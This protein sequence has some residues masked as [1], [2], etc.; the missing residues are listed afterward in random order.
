VKSF[1]KFIGQE[2]WHRL[3]DSASLCILQVIVVSLVAFNESNRQNDI[4]QLIQTNCW[5]P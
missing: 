3:G 5:E 4:W 2:A 1:F